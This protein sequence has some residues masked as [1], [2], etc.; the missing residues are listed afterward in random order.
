MNP[1]FLERNGS[2][3]GQGDEIDCTTHDD[4]PYSGII[5]VGI[6]N[7]VILVI[8]LSIEKFSIEIFFQIKP[9]LRRSYIQLRHYTN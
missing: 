7:S 8:S 1:L 2:I 6:K 4:V 9:P 3:C 5:S